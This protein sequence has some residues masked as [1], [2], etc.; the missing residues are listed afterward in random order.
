MEGFQN[1]FFYTTIDHH[2]YAKN[3]IFGHRFHIEHKHDVWISQVR[4]VNSFIYLVSNFSKIKADI[5]N[6]ARIL[7]GKADYS[8]Y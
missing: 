3:G 5:F 1:E 7:L 2:F 8:T 4:H 6:F